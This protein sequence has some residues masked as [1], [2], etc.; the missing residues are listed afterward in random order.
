MMAR[1]YDTTA[2]ALGGRIV[3]RKDPSM[4]RI[5]SVDQDTHRRQSTPRDPFAQ[6][7]EKVIAVTEVSCDTRTSEASGDSSSS[8]GQKDAADQ[9]RQPGSEACMPMQHPGT[10][11]WHQFGQEYYIPDRLSRARE[12]LVWSQ[13]HLDRRAF[14]VPSRSA[15][16]N[17][18]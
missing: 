16:R 14:V 8:L 1:S 11:Q 7:P 3:D 10:D 12:G 18:P 2:V 17:D 6:T 5:D 15:H 13:S 9:D 4:P